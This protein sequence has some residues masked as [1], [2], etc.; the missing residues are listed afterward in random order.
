MATPQAKAGSSWFMGG[1]TAQIGFDFVDGGDPF[2]LEVTLSGFTKNRFG[3][4]TM[5][6]P[7][8][9]LHCGA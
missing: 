5:L 1:A 7:Q 3:D 4:K 9:F 8:S 6:D 2:A